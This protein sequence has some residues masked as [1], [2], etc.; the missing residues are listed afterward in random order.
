MKRPFKR[1]MRSVALVSSLG[2]LSGLASAQEVRGLGMGGV[3]LPGSSLAQYN[4]AYTAYDAS[5]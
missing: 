3:L 2:V 5:G 1:L 4:P